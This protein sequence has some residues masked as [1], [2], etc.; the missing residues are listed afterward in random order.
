MLIASS[1]W[2]DIAGYTLKYGS[3]IYLFFDAKN[4][5][6]IIKIETKYSSGQEKIGVCD[7]GDYVLHF[8]TGLSLLWYIV[9]H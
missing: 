2:N 1:N 6:T 4:H 7:Q 3:Y 8:I 9:E 5:D